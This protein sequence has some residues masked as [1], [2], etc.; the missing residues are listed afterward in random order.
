MT[1]SEN[2]LQSTMTCKLPN[3]IT[4]CLSAGVDS[5]ALA[6]YLITSRRY[7]ITLYHF[8][9]GTSQADEM[10]EAVNRF[11]GKHHHLITGVMVRKSKSKLK[12][13]AEFR[14]A[15]FAPFNKEPGHNLVT[16]H[17]LNDAVESYLM[18]V[19]R[20]HYNWKVPIKPVSPQGNFTIYHPYLTKTKRNLR[21]YCEKNDLMQFVVED[22][23]NTENICR[24]NFVRNKVIPMLASER[25]HLEKIVKKQY[26]EYKN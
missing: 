20:G 16:A 24:R 2:V 7:S 18:N 22:K 9:H 8:N 12:T 6:H 19:F 25:I 14:A 26:L 21:Q 15:R 5:V 13:E 1:Y 4:I 3:K 17:H 23:T 10:E 11:S